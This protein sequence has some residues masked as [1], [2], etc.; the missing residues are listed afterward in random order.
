VSRRSKAASQDNF[1]GITRFKS[2]CIAEKMA[3]FI[4]VISNQANYSFIRKSVPDNISRDD[5]SSKQGSL[6]TFKLIL[7][8]MSQKYF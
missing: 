5:L 2:Q 4:D 6:F 1:R 3:D 8:K 7:I